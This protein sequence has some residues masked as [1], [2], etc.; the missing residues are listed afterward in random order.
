M[1]L[2]SNGIYT[3]VYIY[4]YAL[5]H[6]HVHSDLARTHTGADGV[7]ASMRRSYG[8][9]V[10]YSQRCS[11]SEEGQQSSDYYWPQHGW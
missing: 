8:G 9:H 3:C 7:A 4:I 1:I 11:A 5:A 6:A 10:I 2:D